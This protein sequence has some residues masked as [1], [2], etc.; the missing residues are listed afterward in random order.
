MSVL[1]RMLPC[2]CRT[3]RC[4]LHYAAR[5]LAVPAAIAGIALNLYIAH[6]FGLI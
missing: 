6:G 4:R 1:N 3:W 2:P 5:V